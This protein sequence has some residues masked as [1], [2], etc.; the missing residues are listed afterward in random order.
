MFNMCQPAY[1]GFSLKKKKK[2]FYNI[3]MRHCVYYYYININLICFYI[4]RYV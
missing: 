1:N 3:G 2:S 4:E